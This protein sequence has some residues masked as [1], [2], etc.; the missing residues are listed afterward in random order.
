MSVLTRATWCNIPED[1]ILHSRC[2]EI[3][4]SY[5]KST[6]LSRIILVMDKIIKLKHEEDRYKSICYTDH[7]KTKA[8]A[9]F[10][11]A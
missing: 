11:K 3:L 8:L 10:V 5:M 2:R 4:K 6:S 7:A 9:H 1:D